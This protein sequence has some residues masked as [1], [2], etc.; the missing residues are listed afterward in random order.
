MRS[1]ARANRQDL[2][3]AAEALLNVHGPTVSL[4]AVAQEAG[5]GVGT[6]YRH[7]PPAGTC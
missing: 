6:L 5:L 2:L 3:E 7:S 1:D 4:R